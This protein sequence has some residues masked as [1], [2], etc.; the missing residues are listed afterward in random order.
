MESAIPKLEFSYFENDYLAFLLNYYPKY[1]EKL[2]IL[3]FTP[4]AYSGY[5]QFFKKNSSV[6][7]AQH[8]IPP[9]VIETVSSYYFRQIIELRMNLGIDNLLTLARSLH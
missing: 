2:N 5:L 1:A 8:K 9:S 3:H 6:A 4:R 7:V